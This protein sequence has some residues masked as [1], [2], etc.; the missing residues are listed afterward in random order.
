MAKRIKVARNQTKSAI[1]N[2]SRQIQ[3][4]AKLVSSSAQIVDPMQSGKEFKRNARQL[5]SGVKDIAKG[6]FN[7]LKD[8]GKNIFKFVTNHPEWYTNY[9][10]DNLVSLNF[11]FRKS[12]ST[13]IDDVIT[14]EGGLD[15]LGGNMATACNIP[16]D[17][18][19][20]KDENSAFIQAVNLVYA[21]IRSANSGQTNYNPTSL[22]KYILNVRSIRAALSQIRRM[23][24][25]TYASDPYDSDSPKLITQL[26]GGA[27]FAPDNATYYGLDFDTITRHAADLQNNL[28]L[29]FKQVRANLPMN[30]PLFDRTDWMFSNIFTDSNDAKACYYAFTLRDVP[31][32]ESNSA[33]TNITRTNIS[34]R[35][36]NTTSFEDNYNKLISNINRLIHEVIS[37][38]ENITIAGD[39]L[40]AFGNAAFYSQHEYPIGTACP[41][42]FD[43]AALTQIQNTTPV[44]TGDQ[45]LMTETY[46]V[47]DNNHEIIYQHNAGA[48]DWLEQNPSANL[49]N[50]YKNKIS[51][52]EVI[53]FTRLSVYGKM[54]EEDTEY[55]IESCGTEIALD[56]Q[57]YIDYD[58]E[59]QCY[60]NVSYAQVQG[61]NLTKAL[62]VANA[63]SIMDYAPLLFLPFSTTAGSILWDFNNWALVGKSQL[64]IFHQYA[65]MSLLYVDDHIQRQNEFN[66][67]TK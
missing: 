59:H 44:C 51:P 22:A 10:L 26:A 9:N 18:V 62:L 25:A 6:G 39:I 7:F 34:L 23:L 66:F 42:I 14:L 15:A 67:I 20:P 56:V 3:G 38:K 41:I 43:E 55:T 27:E 64:S 48:V 16:V 12:L 4:L 8:T 17:L 1:N 19:I 47:A 45:G 40:K 58:N 29:W 57:F 49:V 63:W 35:P 36:A 32:Y 31:L 5:V 53:S 11:G 60:S 2:S 61:T 54:N 37:N 13:K 30:I 65:V 28:M 21:K 33:G 24:A 50:S 52:G 46:Q